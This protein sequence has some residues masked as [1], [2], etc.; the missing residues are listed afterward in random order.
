LL[1]PKRGIWRRY[2]VGAMLIVIASAAATGVAAF[3]ELNSV[4]DVFRRNEQL[5][6][7]N[8]LTQADA[9]K[10]QTILLIGSDTRAKGAR[11]Y[12]AGDR[13][14]SDTMMLLRLDPSQNQIGVLSLP[15]DL[16]VQI[17][18]HGVDKL[19]AAYSYGGVKLTLKTIKLFTGLGVNHV[20][21]IDFRGF[22]KAVD[23][24]GCVYADVDRRYFN[25]NVG[26]EQYATIDLQPGYQKL[27]GQDALDYVRYR[28]T[29]NDIIRAARQQDFL[30]QLKAQ[31]GVGKIIRDRKK[32]LKIFGQHTQS[33]IRSRKS[34]FSLL[35]LVVKSADLPIHQ[36]QFTGELGASYV[37]ATSEQ[38]H[39]LADEFLGAGAEPKAKKR[40]KRR[41][42]GT[43]AVRLID[44]S[45]IGKQMALQLVNQGAKGLDLYYPRQL[46]PGAQF[47]APPRYY[48]IRGKSRRKK[49]R[50][51][52][53]VIG[54]GRI[55]EYYGLQGTTWKK[56][57]I[58]SGPS[59]DRRVSGRKVQIY[60]DKDRVRLI[61]WRAHGAAYWL[62][63]TLTQKLTLPQMLAIVRA[64]RPL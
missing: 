34:V 4:V 50:A 45:G 49:Y 44:S 53:M 13:G 46:T 9:G 7:G 30:R 26:G 41:K 52:R 16:K 56:P 31:I 58:L 33:D 64:T 10:P 25:N 8:D 23:A 17:P 1:E 29:D 19:N 15:R 39:R 11:D 21:N 48:T 6:L 43:E 57:P 27:C 32:L 22:R 54:Y 63:N 36:I 20:I 37:T 24:L 2:V 51:F 12:S 61:S 28:H 59:E 38:T 55:G 3:S 35:K 60:Y 5:Q 42:R 47:I 62:T 18:G 40:R 14:R